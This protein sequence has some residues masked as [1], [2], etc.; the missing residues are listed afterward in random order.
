MNNFLNDNNNY[1]KDGKIH[2]V[3]HVINALN[4]RTCIGEEVELINYIIPII[5]ICQNKKMKSI[6]ETLEK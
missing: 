6:L 1:F 4:E 2:L 5:F 3:L